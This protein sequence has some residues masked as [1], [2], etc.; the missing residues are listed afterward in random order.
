MRKFADE[1]VLKGK[2]VIA[3]F[4]CPTK[5]T[6]EDFNPD[7]TIWMNT[8][9][10]GRFED[11]NKMFEPPLEQEVD[12]IIKEKNAEIIKEELSKKIEKFQKNK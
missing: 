8:I 1:K 9:S 5:N 6:R 4:I 10:K 2:N 3:D 12:F 7:F 11:T